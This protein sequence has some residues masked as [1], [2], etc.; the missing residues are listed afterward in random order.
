MTGQLMEFQPTMWF[1]SRQEL[2]STRFSVSVS[3]SR[4]WTL[5]R[6]WTCQ[7][8][9]T[10][11]QT[12]SKIHSSRIQTRLLSAI[13]SLN[14][15][16]DF[17]Y[18]LITQALWNNIQWQPTDYIMIVS[19]ILMV[20][21]RCYV[22]YSRVYNSTVRCRDISGMEGVNILSGINNLNCKSDN[23]WEHDIDHTMSG[24]YKERWS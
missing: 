9:S 21:V 23:N 3:R 12:L 24:K 16:L 22:Q 11:I 6:R 2:T 14:Q 18:P 19:E 8:S 4:D 7:S 15:N 5:E 20:L 10:L 1:H 17:N 13:H